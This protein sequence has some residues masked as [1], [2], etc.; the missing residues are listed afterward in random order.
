MK[1]IYELKA[2][3]VAERI[4]VIEYQVNGKNMV[5]YSNYPIARETVKVSIN[6][7]N[8]VESRK[9]LKNYLKK[10]NYNHCV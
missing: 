9:V 5:Y 4:G 6:L 7:D 2:L 3:K 10:G 8:A 1:G